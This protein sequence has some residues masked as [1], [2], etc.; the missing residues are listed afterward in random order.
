[1]PCGLGLETLRFTVVRLYRFILV[2]LVGN[3]ILPGG[4]MCTWAVYLGDV[5]CYFNQNMGS[6]LTKRT[7]VIDSISRPAKKFLHFNCSFSFFPYASLRISASFIHISNKGMQYFT[8]STVISPSERC[9]YTTDNCPLRL[10]CQK[11]YSY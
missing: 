3:Y 7:A 11:D 5:G 6:F 10:S 8:L 9:S 1:M 2:N 4:L